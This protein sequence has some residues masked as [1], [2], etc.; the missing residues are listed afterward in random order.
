MD[1]R[2]NPRLDLRSPVEPERG[3]GSYLIAAV[4]AA[5]VIWTVEQ[6]WAQDSNPT[7]VQAP[8]AP[9]IRQSARSDVRAVFS[10]DDY[11]ADAQR[12]NEQGTV[13]AK[14]A[15]DAKG[16]VSGCT[17][18]RSSGHN[19]LDRATCSILQR[20]ARF[21]PALDGSG[22]PVRSSYVTPPVVWRLE[23]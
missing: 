8:A 7:S 12:N 15:I 1:T 20:R 6:N 14:L 18:L 3:R 2:D 5:V 16:R 4:V 21:T 10:A 9:T 23:G 19:S 22:K 17:V 11:P 13:Q